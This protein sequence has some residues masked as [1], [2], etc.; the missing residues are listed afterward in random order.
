MQLRGSRWDEHGMR[1]IYPGVSRICTPRRTI[2]LRFPCISVHP[3]MLIK[4]VLGGRDRA[5][6]E[7]HLQAKIKWTKWYTPRLWSSKF[8]HEI[9]GRDRVNS[10][11]HS[12]LWSSEF[13]DALAAGHHRGRL[14]EYLE[15]VD[16]RR[17]RC[18]DSIHRLVDS[19]Q[20]N[21]EIHLEG[22][23]EWTQ[24]CTGRPWLSEFGDALWGRDRASLDMHM[25][26]MIGRDWRSTWKRSIWS[27]A[28]DHG[29]ML[30][31][32]DAVLGVKSWSWHGEIE[33]DDLTPCS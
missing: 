1:S 28:V 10:V 7:M 33:R 17:A 2:H 5:S 6:W 13:R 15:A 27:E 26:A 23:I 31:L 30:Y 19:D 16:G 4:D 8:G 21:S 22:R 32:M 20:V 9:G 3:P 25:L 18:R 29:M 11:M 12:E 24:R 14:E